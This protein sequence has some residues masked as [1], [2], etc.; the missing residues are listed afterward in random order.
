MSTPG[1][2]TPQQQPPQECPHQQGPH[3]Q[4][5]PQECQPQEHPPQEGTSADRRARE[6]LLRRAQLRDQARWIANATRL[7]DYVCWKVLCCQSLL[8]RGELTDPHYRREF[9][10]H[11]ADELQEGL[12]EITQQLAW[13]RFDHP[14][15][16]TVPELLTR[17]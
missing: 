10:V 11:L 5:P 15:L 13:L 16:P 6:A 1:Q 4:Q 7:P 2:E 14:E 3:Q 8:V 17:P 12:D 9:E